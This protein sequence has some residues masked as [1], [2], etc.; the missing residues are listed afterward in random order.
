MDKENNPNGGAFI[1]SRTRPPSSYTPDE[2]E[3]AYSAVTTYADLSEE[4]AQAHQAIL[5]WFREERDDGSYHGQVLAL[6]GYA[7][8]GKTTLLGVIA[9]TLCSSY[10]VA[11]C[12]FTGRAVSVLR[13]VLKRAG[14][15]PA[16]IGTIHMLLY[17]P[18]ADKHGGLKRFEKKPVQDIANSY[19]LIV[20]DEASMVGE[21]MA[22]DLSAPSLPILAVGDH[23]QLPP[24]N[25][26]SYWM[27]NPHIRL[28]TIHRQAAGSPIIAL[29]THI[30][31]HQT[32]DN[33]PADGKAVDVIRPHQLND[34]LLAAYREYT[35]RDVAI[36][37][38]TNQLRT[39]LNAHAHYLW[40]GQEPHE[41]PA[42][43]TWIICLRNNYNA[44]VMNGMRAYL[45]A[46]AMLQRK[47]YLLRTKMYYPD[48]QLEV[49]ADIFRHQLHHK[50]TY[51]DMEEV[52][53]VC[54]IS[55][56][57]RSFKWQDLGLLLDYGYA[58]T[59]HKAQGGQFKHVFL[60]YE[61]QRHVSKSDFA[62]WLYTG[63]TRS[64]NR[65]TLV[66]N[67]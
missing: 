37:V 28:E 38:Y 51:S 42:K 10:R 29:A 18:I 27:A 54:G 11:F 12:A 15:N 45:E 32:L 13:R 33:F 58:L 19:D 47:D 35:P 25:E 17:R 50:T 55:K 53:D 40:T 30:R 14:A 62:R 6:G 44:A 41:L 8:S 48:E 26:E 22:A 56:S 23:G 65:L 4:Q 31:T 59:V 66:L 57:D 39:T 5:Q 21:E 7:G 3:E 16:F 52:K 24:I 49:H 34:A 20:V 67:G 36:L 43:N 2:V 1:E 9:N 64:A 60:V 61:H 63:V 46:P